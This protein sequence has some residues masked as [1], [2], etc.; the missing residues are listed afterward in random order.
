MTEHPR[1]APDNDTEPFW[2]GCH[3]HALTLQQCDDCATYRFPPRPR[4]PSC[5]SDAVSWQQGSGNGT[6]ASY[7]LCHPPVLPAFAERTP[8]NVIV[9]QLDEGPFIV[10]NLIDGAPEIGARVSVTFT[11]IDDELT[12]PQFTRS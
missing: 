3:E 12:L 10:S 7:T 5:R 4:C 6:I 8:Y 2:A 11:D 9:V 1:A